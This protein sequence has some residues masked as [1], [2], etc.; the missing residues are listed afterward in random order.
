MR[1]LHEIQFFWVCLKIILLW[2]YEFLE[3]TNSNS[4]NA[5]AIGSIY[6]YQGGKTKML[7]GNIIVSQVGKVGLLSRNTNSDTNIEII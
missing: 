3:K 4:T 2:N 6:Q 1:F 5:Y 7:E